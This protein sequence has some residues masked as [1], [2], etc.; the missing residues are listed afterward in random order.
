ML[1]TVDDTGRAL[2]SEEEAVVLSACRAICIGW[3]ESKSEYIARILCTL[4]FEIETLGYSGQHAV[5]LLYPAVMLALNTGMRYNEIP[6][7]QW[8]QP[9]F[10]GKILTVGKSKTQSGTG[11][12]YH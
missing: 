4:T 2:T 1:A 12:S 9:E 8:K 5:E 3:Y 10:M 6:L 11:V 7:L